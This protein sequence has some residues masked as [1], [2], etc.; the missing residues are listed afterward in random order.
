[1]VYNLEPLV[2]II[3]VTILE[4]GHCMYL[5]AVGFQMIS[6]L[7]T[8]T[9]LP[10]S[11]TFLS[12]FIMFVTTELTVNF[13]TFIAFLCICAVRFLPR[14]TPGSAFAAPLFTFVDELE[15]FQL[16]PN[17]LTFLVDSS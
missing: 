17:S 3:V 15:A 9:C 14:G 13:H 11:R 10:P 16:S 1:M 4:L 12:A 2:T 6:T 7:T 5:L 8:V